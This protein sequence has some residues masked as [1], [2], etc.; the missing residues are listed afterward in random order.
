MQH[1]RNIRISIKEHV[2][3]ALEDPG[4]GG[5]SAYNVYGENSLPQRNTSF[6]PVFPY[7]FLIDSN[8][9]PTKSDLPLIVVE[10]NPIIRRTTEL[11]RQARSGELNLHIFGR[12]RGERDDLAS[13]LQDWLTTSGS[14]H[15]LSIKD[16]TAGAGQPV[17]DTGKFGPVAVWSVLPIPEWQREEASLTNYNVVSTEVMFKTL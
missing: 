1:N 14:G 6:V 10:V 4:V 12:S 13:Y 16:Y 5:P 11:G 2:K 9:E 17:V 15:T 8:V 7:V 3:S